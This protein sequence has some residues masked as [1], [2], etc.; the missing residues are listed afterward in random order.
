MHLT[1]LWM[2]SAFTV[3]NGGTVIVPGSHRSRN[4]PTGDNG[5]EP[6]EPYPTEM[7][8]TGKAGSV[9]VMD[10]RLWHATAPNR[11]DEPRVSVVFRY[12][13]W[14]L[15]TK[16]LMPG[17]PERARMVEEAQGA[18]PEQP[19]LPVEVFENLPEAAKPLFEHWLDD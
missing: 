16:I 9:L 12:A 2:L 6:M 4:N 3:E 17:S 15:N 13:P 5:V 14:W 8:V 7:N 18:N 19:A 11:S 10:S 1:T